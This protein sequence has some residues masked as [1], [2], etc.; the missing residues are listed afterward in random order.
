MSVDNTKEYKDEEITA[1][2]KV[3]G[4][5]DTAG[6]LGANPQNIEDLMNCYQYFMKVASNPMNIIGVDKIYLQPWL[7]HP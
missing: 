3:Y 7:M 5:N 6:I 2:L 1:T 4:I